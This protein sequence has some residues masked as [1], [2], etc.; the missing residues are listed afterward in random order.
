MEANNTWFGIGH[1]GADPVLR[2]TDSG[3]SVCNFR[4]AV[5]RSYKQGGR[6]VSQTTWIPVVAWRQNA[7]H[8]AKWLQKGSQ[9]SVTGRLETRQWTDKDGNNHS[10]FEI[11]AGDVKF[12]SGIRA[13][14]DTTVADA[15]V[16][17]AAGE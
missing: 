6:T 1:L 3:D 15:A 8:Y 2:K 9:V 10:S 12:L 4:I 7:E 13:K 5:D 16:A 14:T 11:V 17:L